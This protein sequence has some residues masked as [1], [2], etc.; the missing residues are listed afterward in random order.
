MMIKSFLVFCV[1]LTACCCAHAQ[2]M[3]SGT[4]FDNT[5]INY[6]E[7]VR[8][9]STGGM[10]AITDSLGHYSI[11]V[12]YEDSLS[13]V[14][15]NKPTQQFAVA[16]IA[17]PQKFDISLHL[18]VKGKYSLL[19]EVVVFANSY[20]Q[21]SLE[22]RQ[23]YA[24]VF[25]YHKPGLSTSIGPGGVAGADVNELINIFRFRR[26]RQLRSFQNRL[27][28]QEEDKYIDFRF[29]KIF[30]KRLTHLAGAPLDSFLVWYRPSY[31][32]ARNSNEIVFNQYILNSFYEFEK[33][34]TLLGPAKKE[35]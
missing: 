1:F 21:D 14:Y 5:K 22:N 26:N 13:F 16:T 35:E 9:V 27:A 34:Y 12:H 6:V 20:K 17:N 33:L 11:P 19:Q 32:F 8:V 18:K 25:D 2:V 28:Q 31:D 15:S 7:N 10:F 3:V 23:T 29:N 4:V 24:D 30:V